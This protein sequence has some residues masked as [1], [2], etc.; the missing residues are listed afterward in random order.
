M[1]DLQWLHAPLACDVL[2]LRRMLLVDSQVNTRRVQK[3]QAED[4]ERARANSKLTQ[5]KEKEKEEKDKEKESAKVL[6]R[7]WDFCSTPGFIILFWCELS[8]LYG[9]HISTVLSE[10]LTASVGIVKVHFL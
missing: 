10:K 2:H 7:F 8:G 9:G 5:E 1:L 6:S 3:N 4:L